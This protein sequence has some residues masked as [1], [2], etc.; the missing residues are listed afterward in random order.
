MTRLVLREVARWARAVAV[1]AVSL[2]ALVALQ[3]TAPRLIGAAP[4]ALQLA[5]TAALG[6]AALWLA[7]SIARAARVPHRD[8][9]AAQ[10]LQDLR[11]RAGLPD[12]ELLCVLRVLWDSP[13]GQL[14]AAVDVRSGTTREVWLSESHVA[15]GAY[16]LVAFR[17][18]AGTL[19]DTATPTAVVAAKRHESRHA[20]KGTHPEADAQAS[21]RDRRAAA[22]VIRAAEALL[23]RT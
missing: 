18:G 5:W 9:R 16:A 10:H 15:V 6:A 20:P 13:A 23:R 3:A 12:H 7:I 19:L 2:A 21:R 4:R 22:E 17:H 1:P 8:R 14:V 11:V